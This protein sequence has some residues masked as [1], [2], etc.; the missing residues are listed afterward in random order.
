MRSNSLR[1]GGKSIELCL[2][3]WS[4]DEK[5]LGFDSLKMRN[6]PCSVRSEIEG[7]SLF[8]PLFFHFKPPGALTVK[9]ATSDKGLPSLAP[10]LRGAQLSS[11]RPVP[12]IA[13]GSTPGC[14]ISTPIISRN[15]R[16][17]IHTLV[18]EGTMPRLTDKRRPLWMEPRGLGCWVERGGR[19]S[20]TC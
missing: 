14:W 15:S 2:F 6:L 1:G 10:A 3:L 13:Q 16:G 20:L 18:Q 4:L 8:F 7:G 19:P 12:P 9:G 11:S 17:A 5:D